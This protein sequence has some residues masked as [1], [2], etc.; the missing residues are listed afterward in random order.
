VKRP[1]HVVLITLNSLAELDLRPREEAKALAAAGYRV[2]YI[3]GT[4]DAARARD[5]FPPSISV[6]LYPMP[7]ERRGIVNQVR[8]QVVALCRAGRVV[9]RVAGEGPIDVIHASNPPDHVWLL[10]ELVTLRRG[11]RPKF[12]YDQHDV[13]PLLAA[14]KFAGGWLASVLVRI[15]ESLE[16]CS[17]S[18]ASLI[19]F[20]N[21]AFRRRADARGLR[22]RAHAIVRNG[23]A[24]T[25]GAHEAASAPTIAYVGAVNEQDNVENLVDAIAHLPKTRD[26]RVIVVGDGT[27]LDACKARAGEAGIGDSFEW[28]GWVA[29]RSVLANV[30]G[31]AAV[32]VAPE[33]DSPLNRVT[34]FVK[35]IEYMSVGAPIAAHRLPETETL[36]GD[37][38][39]YAEAMTPES[40]A[41]ALEYIL[42]NPEAAR[43][44]GE[45][46]R[47]RYNE[48]VRWDRVG[49]PRLVLAYERAIGLPQ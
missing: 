24:L 28:L 17:F 4:T 1:R 22:V 27:A 32:C 20:A 3:S 41:A 6:E 47:K 5:H 30:I 40:L 12:V 16:R 15:L 45:A 37:A 19:I 29:D 36:C 48:T 42:T 26:V 35:L 18:R 14:E 25:G 39:H 38:I 31:G 46:A 21:E 2:T 7:D 49:A 34:T 10:R 44:Y 9:L 11:R 13:A 23:W 43:A 33:R 8:E